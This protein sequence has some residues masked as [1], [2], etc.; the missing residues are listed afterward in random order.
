MMVTCIAQNDVNIIR[1]VD[2]VTPRLCH[3]IDVIVMTS[4]SSS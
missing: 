3:L 4:S 1:I 2:F